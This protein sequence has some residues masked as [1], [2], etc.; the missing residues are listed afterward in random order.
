MLRLGVNC[1]RTWWGLLLGWLLAWASVPAL[2]LSGNAQ[3]NLAGAGKFD[4][5]ALGIE[6]MVGREPMKVADWHALCFAYS[7]IKRYSRIMDCLDNFEKALSASDKRSRLFGL[8]DATPTAYQMRAEALIELGQYEPA[9]AQTERV[10]TWYRS[11]QSD[12]VDILINALAARSLASG[13]LGKRADAEK[14]AAELEALP[15]GML[16]G[17]QIGAKSLAMA[18]VNM[19]LGRWQKTLDALAQDKTLG[20]RS[21]LDNLASGAFLRGVNN[22]VW[23]ELPRGFMQNKALFELGRMQEAK[24]GYD[25]MLSVPQIA[26][27]GEIYWLVLLDR[28]RIAV[29]ENQLERAAELFGRAADVV[30]QQRA[31]ISTE[32]NKIGF[33]GDKQAIYAGLVEVLYKLGRHGAAFE[34][35]ERAKSRALVDMLA[36]RSS[37]AAPKRAHLNAAQIQGVLDRLG[38]ADLDARQ[39][40]PASVSSRSAASSRV[41]ARELPPAM[42]SLVSV[43]TLDVAE[44]QKLLG[45]DEA[46]LVYFAH[47]PRLYAS[48]VQRGAVSG[49][50]INAQGM[51]D[52]IRKLRQE[53]QNQGEVTPQLRSLY[54]RLIAPVK[55]GAGIK[56]LTVVAHGALHYLPF[57]ALND[58]KQDLMDRYSLRM[59]PSSSVLKYLRPSETD[60]LTRMLILGNPDLNNPAYDLPGA[61]QEAQALAK[62]FSAQTLLLRKQASKTAFKALAGD[63]FFIHVASHGQFDATKPLHSGLILS[64]DGQNDGRLTVSDLYQLQLDA[65]LVTLSACETGLGAVASGDD[66]VGLTR[67]F[68]YAGAS[69]VIAS[70]WEVD[71]DATAFLMLRMYEHIQKGGRRDALRKAQIETRAK[72]AHPA[73]WAAFYLTGFN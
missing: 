51:D 68:L 32:A 4:E 31:S 16:G 72:F 71:D 46:L 5:L 3:I 53:L 50:E 54:S 8:D 38:Q 27:N 40:T 52:E 58:G 7:R 13:L 62:H 30:E 63:A 24:T 2:A 65:E 11:E 66:V 60:K 25:R 69:T 33:V 67:G 34:T 59:L 29:Q 73:F 35:M 64:P 20:L 39:Q 47:G 36:T 57:A 70:L 45:A 49:T 18:R 48:L 1:G 14:Y 9:M 55:V 41:L 56:R 12:D 61:Q 22:W 21:F 6:Q 26:A 37:I 28:A 44:V 23:I 15:L 42:A 43:S 17:D 19:A 10:L